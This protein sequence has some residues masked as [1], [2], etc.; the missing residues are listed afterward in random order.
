M[1]NWHSIVTAGRF[2]RRRAASRTG[3]RRRRSQSCRQNPP[4]L[5]QRT[6]ETLGADKPSTATSLVIAKYWAIHWG[7]EVGHIGRRQCLLFLL[8]PVSSMELRKNACLA[9]LEQTDKLILVFHGIA[10]LNLFDNKHPRLRNDR[11][12][13]RLNANS[14]GLLAVAAAKACAFHHH[15]LKCR[16]LNPS[17]DPYIAQLPDSFS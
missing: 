6:G 13:H 2:T 14:F 12:L 5:P 15:P 3:K 17:A 16:P 11:Q 8:P 7:W 4:L 1:G 10:G 9:D